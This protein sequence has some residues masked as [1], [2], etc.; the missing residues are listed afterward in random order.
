MPPVST[1]PRPCAAPSCWADSPATFG[2]P[3]ASEGGKGERDDIRPS[4]APPQTD[5]TYRRHPERSE[6]SHGTIRHRPQSRREVLR[7]AQ[8]E[9][10]SRVQ[11]RKVD[12]LRCSLTTQAEPGHTGR[13]YD[14]V[15]RSQFHRA[16][17]GGWS[18]HLSPAENFMMPD[19]NFVTD[20]LLSRT[21]PS[22]IRRGSMHVV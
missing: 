10:K 8:D 5:K 14:D 17:S 16:L 19:G 15:Y 12:A 21:T 6:G 4:E 2:D 18:P 3:L 20:W 13:A 7:C 22:F 1:T 11:V 9:G